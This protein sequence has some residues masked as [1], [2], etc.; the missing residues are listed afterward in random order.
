MQKLNYG[1][2]NIAEWNCVITTP[3]G[4]KIF[5]Q[6]TIKTHT[7]SFRSLFWINSLKITKIQ[8][9]VNLYQSNSTDVD[10]DIDILKSPTY[11]NHIETKNWATIGLMLA[12]QAFD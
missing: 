8:T 9:K 12:L 7:K 5:I 10:S 11:I 4:G 6:I 2:R 3:L 1:Y